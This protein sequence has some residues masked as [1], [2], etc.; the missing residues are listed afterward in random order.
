LFIVVKRS[1]APQL[2]DSQRPDRIV[3]VPGEDPISIMDQ[4]AVTTSTSRDF[5][6]LLQSPVGIRIRRHIDMR[7]APRPV[8]NDNKHI[9]HPQRHGDSH[10]EVARENRLGMV[11]KVDQR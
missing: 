5:Q 3:E 4:V 2:F 7:Q 6:Q 10:E 1:C 11:R 9:E 8:F